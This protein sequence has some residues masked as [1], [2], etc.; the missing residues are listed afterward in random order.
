[1]PGKRNATRAYLTD[2]LESWLADRRPG[3][4]LHLHLVD[5]SHVIAAIEYDRQI[6]GVMAVAGCSESAAR[7]AALTWPDVDD[8]VR[9]VASGHARVEEPGEVVPWKS[10]R[11]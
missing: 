1:M 10:P 5:R 8:L 3:E 11:A 9:A 4:K 7:R 6:H 2:A